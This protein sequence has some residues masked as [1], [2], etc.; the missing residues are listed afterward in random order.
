MPARD[1]CHDI[2]K[3]ALVKD[4]WQITEDPC[5]LKFGNIDLY[6]DL[7]AE[8]LI[9]ASKEEGKIAVEVK[10]FLSDSPLIEFHA[11]LGQ[12]IN[13]RL[14]L[15][16]NKPDYTLYLAVPSESYY[17]FFQRQLPKLIIQQY[18]LKLLVY[19][20]TKEEIVQWIN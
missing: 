10:C 2:V 16:H 4:G 14:A 11:D 12:F 6:I 9:I 18:Q 20:T 3:H 5:Y 15:F 17:S 13:Y 19:H 8:K 1:T 7:V